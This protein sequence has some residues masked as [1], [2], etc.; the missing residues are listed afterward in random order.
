[1]KCL[2]LEPTLSA[3]FCGWQNFLMLYY[4]V[5]PPRDGTP[6]ICIPNSTERLLVLLP[7]PPGLAM[8]QRSCLTRPDSFEYCSMNLIW[9]G[10]LTW[11]NQYILM[12]KIHEIFFGET[13]KANNFEINFTVNPIVRS[14]A[15]FTRFVNNGFA[16]SKTCILDT[17][18]NWLWTTD[19]HFFQ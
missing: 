12:Q 3:V 17:L 11:R 5:L 9:W 14:H 10:F 16:W 19:L 13:I 18:V 8:H 1:M 6:N 2:K 7:R 4:G 15:R